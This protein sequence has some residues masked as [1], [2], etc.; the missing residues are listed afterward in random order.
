M[1]YWGI[2]LKVFSFVRLVL[3]LQFISRVKCSDKWLITHYRLGV[4]DN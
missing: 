3:L 1:V 4:V 2:F